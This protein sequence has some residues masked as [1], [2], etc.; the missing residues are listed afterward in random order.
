MQKGSHK[1]DGGSGGEGKTKMPQL[2]WYA[3]QNGND[4]NDGQ[5]EATPLATV[6]KALALIKTGYNENREDGRTATIVI[7]G[8]IRGSGNYNTSKSMIEI[9]GAGNYPPIILKG[10]KS[11]GVL[12]ANVPDDGDGRIMYIDNNHVTLESGLVLRGG[13][14]I[15]GGAV[16]IGGH[17][18]ESAGE[19]IMRGGEISGNSAALGGAVMIYNGSFK[20]SGGIIKN[21]HS[22]KTFSA[23]KLKGAAVYVCG[24]ATFYMEGG[25]IKNN[26]N[27]DTDEGGGVAV[28]ERGVFNMKGGYMS[29]NTA[30]NGGAVYI[31][32]LATFTITA[33]IVSGNIAEAG[34]GVYVSDYGAKLSENGG[35][36][37]GNTPDDV[38]RK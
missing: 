10:G 25:E 8:T 23:E 32:S 37:T 28:D 14:S 34:G 11:G 1:G 36:I 19:F 26:G 9:S 13:H 16:I 31:E 33:G 6:S 21:N 2:V 5:S 4:A 29:Q 7:D 17:G 20:L 35:T 15:Y 30:K 12:D 38:Y 18:S 24:G 27:T 3:A 22:A